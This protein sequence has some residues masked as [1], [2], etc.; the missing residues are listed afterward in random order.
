MQVPGRRMHYLFKRSLFCFSEE[1]C[2]FR[3]FPLGKDVYIYRLNMESFFLILKESQSANLG[4]L[5]SGRLC[6]FTILL[7]RL[8]ALI[9]KPRVGIY[10]AQTAVCHAIVDLS[11]FPLTWDQ[12]KYKKDYR[13]ASGKIIIAGY[14]RHILEILSSK[15]ILNNSRFKWVQMLVINATY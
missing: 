3:V 7:D 6:M 10:I 2:L 5:S 4:R 13:I 15:I 9:Y 14:F 1:H 11:F 8:H 12:T